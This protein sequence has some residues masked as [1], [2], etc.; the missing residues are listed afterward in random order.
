M[1]K[2]PIF[3]AVEVLEDRICPSGLNAAVVDYLYQP[4]SLNLDAWTNTLAAAY[5]ASVLNQYQASIQGLGRSAVVANYGTTADDFTKNANGLSQVQQSIIDAINRGALPQEDGH[6]VYGAELTQGQGAIDAAGQ[7]NNFNFAG[8]H[9]FF[10][11]QGLH[12]YYFVMLYVGPQ[13]AGYY[14]QTSLQ[15][16][17]V[18]TSHEIIE[19]VADPSTLGK[20]IADRYV[21]QY[22]LD[23]GG[24][25]FTIAEAA[26]GGA[27]MPPGYLTPEQYLLQ[28]RD[29][30]NGLGDLSAQYA[31]AVDLVFSDLDYLR[32]VYASVLTRLIAPSLS[33][34]FQAA[35]QRE[36]AHIAASPLAGS[37]LGA[38]AIVLGE[39]VF[40]AEIDA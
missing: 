34:D 7:P 30:A 38:Y 9:L 27:V 35:A 23:T 12:Y 10:D 16:Q 13:T 4:G 1:M 40:I 22:F 37:A 39:Q 31:E 14:E 26:D 3:L 2:S 11:Y 21:W 8:Y 17:E 15:H 29:A 36:Q 6:Q 32:F 5:N 20:E 33:R 18:G 24:D 25:A 28:S 19:T